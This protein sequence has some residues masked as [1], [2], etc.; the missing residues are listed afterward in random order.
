M[1][2]LFH[3]DHTLYHVGVG[4]FSIT[5][6]LF[7]VAHLTNS[8]LLFK[9]SLWSSSW[10]TSSIRFGSI[11]ETWYI[12][13]KVYAASLAAER[14]WSRVKVWLQ[15]RNNTSCIFTQPYAT[16]HACYMITSWHGDAI[17]ITGRFERNPLIDHKGPILRCSDIFIVDSEEAVE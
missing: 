17:Q 4:V 12:W 1:I 7:V 15:K 5:E 8:N 6:L 9:T 10:L 14:I 16:A 3:V 2:L 11:T 13:R